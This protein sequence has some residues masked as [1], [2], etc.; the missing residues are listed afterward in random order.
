M[1]VCALNHGVHR[2]PQ[3]EENTIAVKGR[4]RGSGMH[5]DLPGPALHLRARAG[6]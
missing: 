4:G 6:R 5:R 1:V 2:S 3:G